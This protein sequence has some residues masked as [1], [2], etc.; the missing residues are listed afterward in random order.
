VS[1][2]FAIETS[3]TPCFLI[4]SFQIENLEITPEIAKEKREDTESENFSLGE[5]L[6]FDFKNFLE[7]NVMH[8]SKITCD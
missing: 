5:D 3:K 6:E 4:S 1:T 8:L 2:S 7:K